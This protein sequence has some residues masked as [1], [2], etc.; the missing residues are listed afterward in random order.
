MLQL[1]KTYRYCEILLSFTF[2]EYLLFHRL[3]TTIR[4]SLLCDLLAGS[5]IGA[6][7]FHVKVKRLFTKVKIKL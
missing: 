7:E 4:K 2:A 1:T 6:L 5:T 3:V